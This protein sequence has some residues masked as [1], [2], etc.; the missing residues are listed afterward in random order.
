[1]Y[2]VDSSVLIEA[3]NRYYAFDFAPG[4]WEWLERAH[5]AGQICSIEAVKQ[6]LVDGQ[7]ELAGWATNHPD[8]F[9]PIDQAT[10]QHFGPLTAWA[11]SRQFRPAALAKFTGNDADYLLVAFA[12]AHGH[13]VVTHEQPDPA[14]KKNV[15]IPDACAAMG[16]D[17]TNAFDVLRRTGAMLVLRDT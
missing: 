10:T 15:K 7:D 3:K 17:F 8:F 6:E 4:Y 2:L 5:V 13:V 11:A 14:A 1:M 16:V 9:L 12:R